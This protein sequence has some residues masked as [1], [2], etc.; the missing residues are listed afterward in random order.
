MDSYAYY[1]GKFGKKEDI[2]IPISDRSIFFADAIYDAAIGRYDR[3]L[4]EEEHIERFLNNAK[5]IGINHSLTKTFLSSLLREIAIKSMLESYFIYFQLSKNSKDRTHSSVGSSANLLIT[6]DPIEI[7]KVLPPMKLMSFDDTRH[8]L[9]DIKCTNL[10]SAVLTST[11]ADEAGFDEAVFIRNGIV[12][13]C[14]KSNISIIKQGRVISHPKNSHILPGITREHLN[15]VCNK[16][17]IPFW[18]EKFS[19]NDL[20]NADE[21]L[22]TSTTKLC[23]RV[24]KIDNFT[25]GGKAYDLCER[26]IYRLFSEYEEII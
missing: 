14:A 9:C 17:S 19:Y 2:Y 10:L 21:I 15:D 11:I 3:I 4:W 20:I 16:L 26:I 12:T 18:E 7:K 22:V 25:V 24:E 23:R 8:N 13:E 5:R 6:I 1:N